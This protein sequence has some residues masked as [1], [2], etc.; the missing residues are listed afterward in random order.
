M[1]K[2]CEVFLTKLSLEDF[3]TA[4]YTDYRPF[5]TCF[6]TY[7]AL[8]ER[9]H[10]FQKRFISNNRSAVDHTTTS[11]LTLLLMTI[12][13]TSGNLGQ[14]HVYNQYS[15]PY[16]SALLHF[17]A[18]YELIV[19]CSTL[20]RIIWIKSILNSVKLENFYMKTVF[21]HII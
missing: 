2:S 16:N 12:G 21:P 19:N 20:A 1:Y 15:L 4:A 9:Y 3:S 8:L 13:V 7:N 17:I 11:L 10:T 14:V 18:Y 5:I 6:V